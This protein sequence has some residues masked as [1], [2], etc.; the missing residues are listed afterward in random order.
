[1][2]LQF[3]FPFPKSIYKDLQNNNGKV[4]II[5]RNHTSK[6]LSNLIWL[7]IDICVFVH[8]LQVIQI[9][10]RCIYTTNNRKTKILQKIL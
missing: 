2:F 4:K 8:N 1:M 9:E 7:Q 5:M 3:F 6:E 10:I